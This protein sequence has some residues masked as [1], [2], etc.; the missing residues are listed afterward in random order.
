MNYELIAEKYILEW[1]LLPDILIKC[2]IKIHAHG[3]IGKC[4]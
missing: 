1:V 2:I 3:R 4:D